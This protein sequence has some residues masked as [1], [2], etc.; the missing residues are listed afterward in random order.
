L[1]DQDHRLCSS[2]D[3]K[4]TQRAAQEREAASLPRPNP[5]QAVMNPPSGT[6]VAL[7]A[8]AEKAQQVR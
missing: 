3:Y 1:F 2:Q 7:D 4:A 5:M 6:S 8:P